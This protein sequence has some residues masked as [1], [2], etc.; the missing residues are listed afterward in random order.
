MQLGDRRI[1]GLLRDGNKQTGRGSGFRAWWFPAA[2]LELRL[3]LAA[4]WT[5]PSLCSLQFLPRLPRQGCQCSPTLGGFQSHK[6]WQNLT[7]VHLGQFHAFWCREESRNISP[8][9]LSQ[10]NSFFFLTASGSINYPV[11]TVGCPLEFFGARGQDDELCLVERDQGMRS[12]LSYGF[13]FFLLA[14][15]T[16]AWII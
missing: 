13:I 8:T 9:S 3:C 7:S 1:L 11:S 4:G 12:E 14:R 16:R 10:Q 15:S 5:S 6:L 2:F